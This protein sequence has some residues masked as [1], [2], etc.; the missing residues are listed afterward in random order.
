VTHRVR[1]AQNKIW[2]HWNRGEA[3]AAYP[4]VGWEYEDCRRPGTNR[5]WWKT[6]WVGR[7]WRVSRD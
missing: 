3:S 7:G 1:G 4:Y 2:R 5:T 6:R